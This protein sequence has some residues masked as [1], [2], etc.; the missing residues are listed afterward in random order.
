LNASA[1]N[2]PATPAETSGRSVGNNFTLFLKMLGPGLVTGASDDDPS[3]IATYS[4]VGAQFGYGMLWTMLFSYPLM[5]AIQETSA[6]IGR[7]TGCGISANLRK[8]YPAWLLYV[9]VGLVLIAN[10]FNLGADIGAMGAAAHLILPG[11]IG[12]YIVAFGILS[13]ILQ[14]F[15]PYTR[16]VR[17]LKWLTLS[18]FSY[19]ATSF[20]VRIPWSQAL[21][22]TVYPRV[23]LSREYFTAIIAV[24]GTTISPY[25]FFWQASQEVEEVKTNRG[26]KALKRAPEQA[27]E[28]LGR[29]RLDTYIGMGF[30]NLVAFFIILTTAATLHAHGV[31]DVTSSAQAAEALRPLAGHWAFLLFV[32]G[33]VAT[34]LLA[35]PVLAGSAAYA[36]GEALKWRCTLESKPPDAKGFYATITAAT[37]IGLALNFIR[38]DPIKALFWAAVLNGLTAAPLMAVIIRLATN[39]KIMGKFVLS[40]YLKTVGWIAT[41]LMVSAG[42]GLLVTLR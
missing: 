25:L 17:Y 8:A 13:L 32:C 9:A 3:G 4:Q 12:V 22:S 1:T 42:I 7:V 16:Y 41:A 10:I 18:L 36:L 11:Y 20:F 5:A 15:I 30:S 34:G 29:I 21:L 28:Q 35:V 38:I 23:G 33:I 14:L 6:R 31:T 39:Q 40:T 37:V 24:F 27:E 26:E 19:V 2:K